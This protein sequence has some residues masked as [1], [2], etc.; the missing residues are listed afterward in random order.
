MVVTECAASRLML[1]LLHDCVAP[2]LTQN[3]ASLESARQVHIALTL[4]MAG[5][6]CTVD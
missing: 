2:H 4:S 5:S 3:T 6:S 1:V